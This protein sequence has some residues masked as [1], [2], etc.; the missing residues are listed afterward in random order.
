MVLIVANPDLSDAGEIRRWIGTCT[1]IH[2]LV[3]AQDALQEKQQLYRSVLEAS[4]DCIKILALDGRLRLMNGPGVRL[5]ELPDLSAIEGKF[6]WE[7]WPREMQDTVR[8]SVVKAK[9]GE[10]TRFEGP[11]PT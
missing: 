7:C 8:E 6:W 2:D 5:M 10:T 3:I 11:C 4:A 1:D 9:G